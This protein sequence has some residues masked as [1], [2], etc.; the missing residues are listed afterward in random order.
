MTRMLPEFSFKWRSQIVRT[1]TKLAGVIPAESSSSYISYLRIDA[2]YWLLTVII[3][4]DTMAFWTI[5][6]N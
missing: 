2:G 6:L 4:A 1:N 5:Q 3:L